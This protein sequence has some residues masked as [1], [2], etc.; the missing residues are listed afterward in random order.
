MLTIAFWRNRCFTLELYE[1]WEAGGDN[2]PFGDLPYPY[3]R[4]NL[5]Y[6][7]VSFGFGHSLGLA[8]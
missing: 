2:D 4:T 7:S 5:D 8:P 1:L 6:E 3:P